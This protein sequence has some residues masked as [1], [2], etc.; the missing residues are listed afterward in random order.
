MATVCQDLARNGSWVIQRKLGMSREYF[1]HEHLRPSIPVV[2]GDASQH[3]RALQDFSFAFFRQH[4]ADAE[5]LVGRYNALEDRRMRLGEFLELLDG[6]TPDRPAPYPCKLQLDARFPELLQAI[7]PRHAFCLPDHSQHW[8]IPR[9]MRHGA[10]SE[11]FFGGADGLFPYLHVDYAGLHAFIHQIV[12]R[13][14]FVAIPPPQTDCVYPDPADPW[15]STIDDHHN[16][17]LTRFPRYAQATPLHFSIGPG[18]TLFIPNGWWHSARSLEP[19][20]SVNLDALNASNW[21]RFQDDRVRRYPAGWKSAAVKG[22]LSLSGR[23][24]CG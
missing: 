12:G 9:S 13:K 7:S 5:V 3:W 2:I 18:D 19:T 8:L 21:Q 15:R 23:L 11:V 14:A 16:P 24:L 22:W 1:E 4:Y 10:C 6:A 17:D 20:I